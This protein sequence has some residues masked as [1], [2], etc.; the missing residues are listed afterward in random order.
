MKETFV[1]VTSSDVGKQILR[2]LDTSSLSGNHKIRAYIYM[3]TSNMNAVF[4][5]V[6][7]KLEGLSVL[8][9]FG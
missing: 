8:N 3:S 7:Q 5:A 4:S 6:L 9:Q 2:V 1:S